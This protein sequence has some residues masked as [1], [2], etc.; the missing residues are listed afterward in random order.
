MPQPK[1]L[2]PLSLIKEFL[3]YQPSTGA[4][5][6]RKRPSI[7]VPL[8]SVA[9][10]LCPLSRNPDGGYITIQFKRQLYKAH[11]LAWLYMTGEDPG[12]REIDHI[13]GDRSDNRFENLRLA[14]RS[15]Q[16]WNLKKPVTNKSGQKGLWWDSKKSLWLA[17]VRKDGVIY[18]KRSKSRKVA[19]EW[20]Y[21]KRRELH[22]EFTRHA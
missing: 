21:Q 5:T 8:G 9:G 1:P 16:S 17:Y 10:S 20:L 13:N 11:R 3:H 6:W 15:G 4:W 2:P 14:E 22:G 18:K 7:K 12:E 19:L